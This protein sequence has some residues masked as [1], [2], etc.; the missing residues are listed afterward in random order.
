MGHQ[1]KE[2]GYIVL[3]DA[4]PIEVN[5]M[6]NIEVYLVYHEMAIQEV[7]FQTFPFIVTQADPFHCCLF[8]GV[9]QVLPFQYFNGYEVGACVD[10]HIVA[11]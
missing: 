8:I 10:C 5:S 2:N 6:Q 1:R 7:P 4:P 9:A 3:T 11:I